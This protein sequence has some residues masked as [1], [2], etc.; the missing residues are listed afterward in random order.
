[1][2]LK[3][4]LVYIIWIFNWISFGVFAGTIP[5]HMEC[6]H[7]SSSNNTVFLFPK[8]L[9]L[10]FVNSDVIPSDIYGLEFKDP[11]SNITYAVSGMKYNIDF[12]VTLDKLVT[13]QQSNKE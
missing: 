11:N 10:F 2:T 4:V 6:P 9:G 5:L 3:S 1:M 7:T 12:A 13:D 8:N